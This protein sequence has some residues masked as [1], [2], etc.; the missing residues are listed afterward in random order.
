VAPEKEMPMHDPNRLNCT[1]AGKG[2]VDFEGI[3][4]VL[5]ANKFNGMVLIEISRLHSDYDHID[6]TEV[7][8]TGITYLK[9]LRKKI[10]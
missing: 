3:F 1:P 4:K 5:R 9:G 10:N 2:V 8:N 7:I 6:E